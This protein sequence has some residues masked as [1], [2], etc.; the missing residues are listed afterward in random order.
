MSRSRKR[1][2]DEL[3]QLKSENKELR[4][5]VKSLERQLKKLNKEFKAEYN[6]DELIE[7]DI[8]DKTP[9]KQKCHKC[10]RGNIQIVEL[11]PKRLENC[12]VCDYRKLLK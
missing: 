4:S 3:E 7:E 8:K 11:G 12:T 1:D 10:A 9:K 5:T 2:L 6:Q